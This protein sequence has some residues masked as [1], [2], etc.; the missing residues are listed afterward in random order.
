MAKYDIFISYRREGG[1]DTAKHLYDLLTRDG[2]KVS[3]DIDTLRNGDFDEALLKRIDECKDFILII[4]VHAFDRTLNPKFNPNNDWMRQ[5]L[6]YALKKGKNIVP[7]FLNG[8]Q[9]F[10]VNLPV[11]ISAVTKK[12]GPK[13]DRYYFNDFYAKLKLNFLT[14]RSRGKLKVIIIVCSLTL[15][16]LSTLCYI[17]KDF[18]F[19]ENY[20][21]HQTVQYNKDVEFPTDRELK[22]AIN[23]FTGQIKE[24]NNAWWSVLSRNKFLTPLTTEYEATPESDEF[25]FYPIRMQ[26]RGKML[27]NGIPYT[28]TN[29]GE[30]STLTISLY[31][32]NAGPF[33]M[34][35]DPDCALNDDLN[36]ENIGNFL[37]FEFKKLINGETG[38]GDESY[39]FKQNRFILIVRN[40]I[41]SGGCFP[42][43]VLTSL[44]VLKQDDGFKSIFSPQ[45]LSYIKSH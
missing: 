4:D 39:I 29:I 2:Y 32:S 41:G 37:G 42:S 44:E 38:Y 11:D 30:E 24:H 27:I 12:N 13:Y 22:S 14:S 23:E 18:I 1:Y 7:I 45:I 35:I 9:G 19:S 43:I 5:E 25:N 3:F 17:F 6:A 8:V 28:E 33:L 20:D 36:V 26:Y 15:I 16:L 34:T 10:P 40:S 31:G 21:S